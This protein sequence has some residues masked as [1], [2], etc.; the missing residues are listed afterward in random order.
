LSVTSRIRCATLW[1][2]N[3]FDGN[4]PGRQASV[5][6]TT[7]RGWLLLE[8]ATRAMAWPGTNPASA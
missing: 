1:P 7:V 3:S 8:S 5:T 4:Q 6:V 2:Q